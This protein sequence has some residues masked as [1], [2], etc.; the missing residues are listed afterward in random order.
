MRDFNSLIVMQSRIQLELSE[1]LLI[2]QNG[3]GRVQISDQIY[4]NLKIFDQAWNYTIKK[5]PEIIP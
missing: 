2:Q 4:I 1:L 5:K 3:F